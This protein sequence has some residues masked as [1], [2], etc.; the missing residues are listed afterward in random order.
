MKLCAFNTGIFQILEMLN[1][2]YALYLRHES[3]L[4]L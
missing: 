1:Q 4:V 3:P 2:R